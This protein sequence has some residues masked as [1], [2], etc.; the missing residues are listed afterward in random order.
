MNT[1]GAQVDRPARR[2]RRLS[3]RRRRDLRRWTLYALTALLVGW[4]AVNADWARLQQVFLDPDIARGLFPEVVT[5]AA[6]N[7]V[8][9]ALLAFVGGLTL[10]LL[11]ALMRLS[12]IAPYRWASLVYIEIFRGIPAILTLILVGYVLPIALGIRVRELLP[13]LG[14]YGPPAVGLSIVAGA[15]LAETIRGGIEAVPKGQREAAR[16]LGMSE[17]RTMTS[18]VLPQAFRI[19]IPPMT[20]EFVLLIKD[21]SLIFVLGVAAA[22]R[23]LTFFTRAEVQRTFNGTP[24]V[25]AALMYL[26]ITLPLTALSRYLERRGP[27]S[28]RKRLRDVGSTPRVAPSNDEVWD[29]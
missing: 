25:V 5:V 1:H 2:A 22:D 13:F 29:G 15:Y 14:N 27:R 23:D 20:N 6:K 4:A 9:L 26:A 11:L 3:P 8:I 7:T 28:P 24:F 12:S 17:A 21:T 16:S 18:I 19:M 10:G